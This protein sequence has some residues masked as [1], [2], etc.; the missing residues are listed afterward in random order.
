MKDDEDFQRLVEAQRLG[1]LLALNDVAEG[2][3]AVK[4][5]NRRREFVRIRDLGWDDLLTVSFGLVLWVGFLK[6]MRFLL[7]G[8]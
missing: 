3:Q 8:G 5:G 1:T 7:Y 2:M 4:D 6:L